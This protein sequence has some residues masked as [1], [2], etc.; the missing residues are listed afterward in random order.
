MKDT[1]HFFPSD[2]PPGNDGMFTDPFRYHPHPSVEK[3]ASL[4][5]KEIGSWSCLPPHSEERKL[6][7]SFA[8]GKMLGILVVETE[9]G[10]GYLAAFSGNA[11]GR[12]NV[13]GFVPPI[14]DLLDPEGEFKKG[15]QELNAL[16]RR[17][18]MMEE[19]AEYESF[20][21]NLAEAERNRDEE[22]SAMRLI[23]SHSKRRRDMMRMECTDPSQLEALL[24]ESRHEKAELKR[25]KRRWE[26]RISAI[27][28]HMERT[29]SEIDECKRQRS[30]LS[31][32]LQKRIFEQYTVSNAVG[33]SMTI[34]EIFA[35]EGLVPPGGTG[36]C[37]A[38]KLLHYAFTHNLKPLH[39]GEFWYGKSPD[40]PVRTHGH[41]YPSCTS[42]CAPLLGFMLKG[43]RTDTHFHV[44]CGSEQNGKNVITAAEGD[45]PKIIH[46]DKDIIIVSKP[47]G[48][49]SVPGLD[50]RVSLQEWLADISA[51][52]AAPIHTVHR[53]DMDTS[54]IMV[55]AKSAAA[56]VF[57]R[58][59]FEEHTV[60]KCY[61]ARL[62][63]ADDVSAIPADG[64]IK[65]PLSPDYDERPRQKVDITQGKEAVTEFVVQSVNADGTVDILFHPLTGRTHQLR[66]HAAH[67]LGLGRPIVGDMLYGGS[68]ADRLCLHAAS[69]SFIH[70]STLAQ[71]NFSTLTNRY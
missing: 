17:I 57:L 37:A 63:P 39:M 26:D 49:P 58:R 35:R 51:K 69:I 48:M 5:M 52:P 40:G 27:R 9:S 13:K 71:V 6:E 8:E 68:P 41:F 7:E 28:M 12:S 42:R 22:I 10:T 45:I 66:V 20:R 32:R 59:Q 53:L 21:K 44:R 46:E 55:F 29:A 56:A 31:D 14:F 23:M 60:I 36:E 38:P 3:A 70:P 18:A 64:K 1:L 67:I 54:G 30:S 16:N 11:G 15:E 34:G 47:S 65:L 43:L 33:E 25:L 62:S 4:I 19:S 50:G 2:I 61:K 24:M